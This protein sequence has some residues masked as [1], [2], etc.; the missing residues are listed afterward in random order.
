MSDLVVLIGVLLASFPVGVDDGLGLIVDSKLSYPA[1]VNNL[2]LPKAI[3]GVAPPLQDD[4]AIKC[5]FATCFVKK[6]LAAHIA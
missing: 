2:D 3:L 4:L 5:D 1:F 6:Y